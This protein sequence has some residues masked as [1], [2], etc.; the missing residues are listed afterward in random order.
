M[1][2]KNLL[3]VLGSTAVGKTKL[4]VQLA[5]YFG[6]ELISADSRQVFTGMDIGTGKDLSE[7]VVNGIQV[8]YHLIDIKKAGER[9]HVNAF[10]E[11]FYQAFEEITGRQKLPVLCGGTGMYIHTLL[12]NHQLTSIPVNEN[13]RQQLMPLHKEQLKSKLYEFP[14]ELRTHVDDSSSKRLIRAIEIAQFLS[15]N[16]KLELQKR[17]ALKPLVIGLFNDVATRRDKILSRL[18]DRLANGL[19][20]E[21]Q[22]L[23]TKGVS[24]EMLVFYGLEYKFVVSYLKNEMDLATL[25]ERLGIAICQ[26]AKRQMTFFRKMEKDGVQI[27]WIEAVEDKLAIKNQAINLIEQNF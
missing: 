21:V 2:D 22:T 13:L 24:E 26:F 25:K 15:E 1:S 8:P 19:V 4:A 27:N 11:D 3:I 12:Q 9:Y 5:Q 23:L 10:K 17:P 16:G 20:E 14:L 7:Y 6:G 18:N